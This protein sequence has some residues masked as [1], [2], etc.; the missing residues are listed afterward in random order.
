MGQSES[1]NFEGNQNTYIH[2]CALAEAK[3]GLHRLYYVERLSMAAHVC[4]SGTGWRLASSVAQITAKCS[5]VTSTGKEVDPR[6]ST[7]PDQI[8]CAHQVRT[9]RFSS[10]SLARGVVGI[11]KRR[12]GAGTALHGLSRPTRSAQEDPHRVLKIITETFKRSGQG[13]MEQKIV[14]GTLRCPRKMPSHPSHV[15]V[16]EER[17]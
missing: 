15:G 16:K 1:S 6:C 5:R 3:V 12:A 11:V 8:L 14:S 4:K 9:R 10:H 13:P 7:F 17:T 2:K